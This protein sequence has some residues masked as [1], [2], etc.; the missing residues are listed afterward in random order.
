[1]TEDSISVVYVTTRFEVVEHHRLG[2]VYFYLRKP[3]ATLV[4]VD[5]GQSICLLES[6]RINVP[7]TSFELPGG[8]IEPGETPLEA[9]RR[10]LKEETGLTPLEVESIGATWPLPSVT[11]ERVHFFSA[12]VEANAC[13][14]VSSA[15]RTEGISRV[16]F[17]SYAAARELVATQRVAC[18]VDSLAILLY[19][20]TH[21]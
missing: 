16:S 12:Q 7:G 17:V 18:A 8:R 19:L 2:S 10:E 14:L 11:T 9:A 4:V 13:T 5:A 15:P 21:A 6:E 1:M 3:D 20:N